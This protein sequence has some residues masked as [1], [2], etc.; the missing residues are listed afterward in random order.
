[1]VPLAVAPAVV[2]TASI[3]S[4]TATDPVAGSVAG[5]KATATA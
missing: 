2:A 4:K 1:M 5:A 3:A